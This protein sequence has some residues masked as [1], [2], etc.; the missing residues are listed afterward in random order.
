MNCT[1]ESVF[2]EYSE[3][4]NGVFISVDI[5]IVIPEK[6]NLF[7]EVKEKKYQWEKSIREVKAIGRNGVQLHTP[8]RGNDSLRKAK[9]IAAGRPSYFSGYTPE[10]FDSYAVTYQSE[11]RFALKPVEIPEWTQVG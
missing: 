1:P 7:V 6:L 11:N 3:R 4:V 9:Y 5:G 2:W 10:G 8:D